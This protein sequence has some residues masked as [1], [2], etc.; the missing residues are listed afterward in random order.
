MRHNYKCA[1]YAPFY[2]ISTCLIS[3]LLFAAPSTTHFYPNA[4]F[5]FVGGSNSKEGGG[6]AL[7]TATE[8]SSDAGAVY[9][10]PYVARKTEYIVDDKER[11]KSYQRR[12]ALPF[13][14][15]SRRIN[16]AMHITIKTYHMYLLY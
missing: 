1:K 13:K 10:R 2:C 9:K 15:V 12:R 6:G 11:Y 14:K 7:T 5:Q 3:S 8:N 16:F 4:E